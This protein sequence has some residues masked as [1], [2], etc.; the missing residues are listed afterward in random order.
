MTASTDNLTYGFLDEAPSLQDKTYWEII[1]NLIEQEN[2]ESWLD[3]KSI[4][5]Q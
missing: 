4:Y 1:K 5:K 2:K 3:I